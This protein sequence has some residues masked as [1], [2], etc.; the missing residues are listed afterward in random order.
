MENSKKH[1]NVCG[2]WGKIWAKLDSM[3][4]EKPG[5]WYYQ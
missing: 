1:E 5:I 4:F 3:L 2:L